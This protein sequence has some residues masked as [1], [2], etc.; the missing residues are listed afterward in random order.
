[1]PMS[2]LATAVGI[3]I[4][5]VN[6]VMHFFTVTIPGWFGGSGWAAARIDSISIDWGT[7][8]IVMAG[9]LIQPAGGSAGFNVGNFVYVSSGSGGN[10]A[11]IAHETGHT[12]NVAAFGS[13]FHFVGALDENWPGSRGANAYAE[14]LAE[15]HANRSGRPTVPLWG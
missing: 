14:M 2:W 8:T 6:V 4:F 9:G 13:L 15:S 7:G 10:A 5:V 1:M 12:L 3:I 11:L